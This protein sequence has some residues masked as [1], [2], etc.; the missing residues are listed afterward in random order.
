MDSM[1]LSETIGV[2]II[3]VLV[4]IPIG[5]FLHCFVDWWEDRK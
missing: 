3:I 2:L 4:C 5:F 1:N